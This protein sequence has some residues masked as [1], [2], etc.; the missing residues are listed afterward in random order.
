MK[1]L[2]FNIPYRWKK[3]G[4]ITD[5]NCFLVKSCAPIKQK[6]FDCHILG[7]EYEGLFDRCFIISRTNKQATAR[8]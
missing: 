3:V 8:R 1:Q 5:L 6:S 4:K 7:L 2:Y